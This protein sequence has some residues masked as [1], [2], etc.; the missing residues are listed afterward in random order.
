MAHFEGTI[1]IT[2]P[3]NILNE[4]DWNEENKQERKAPFDVFMIDDNFW[5][6]GKWILRDKKT[7]KVISTYRTF[8][9]FTG[10]F[11]EEDVLKYSPD[12]YKNISR[13]HYVKIDNFKGDITSRV[14]SDK[15][16][17]VWESDGNIN[18]VIYS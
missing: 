2:D 4:T 9:G 15:A 1:I 17:R 12:F 11:L 5:G 13:G 16:I 7:K 18:F 3:G 6:D 14:D 10:V 8:S